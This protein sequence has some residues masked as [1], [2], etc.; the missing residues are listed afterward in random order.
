MHS[1]LI[2]TALQWVLLHLALL[3]GN[4]ALAV[5]LL[6]VAVRLLLSPSEILRL[7]SIR[8][9]ERLQPHIE[10]LRKKHGPEK[11]RLTEETLKLYKEHKAHPALGLL[12]LLQVPILIALFLALWKL[13]ATP[14]KIVL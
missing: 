2:N 9:M 12:T 6:A 5:I 13:G 3:L 4:A 10:E 8:A 1:S 11:R 14:A 7:H